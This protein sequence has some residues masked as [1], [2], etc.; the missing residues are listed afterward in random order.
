MSWGPRLKTIQPIFFFFKILKQSHIVCF[1]GLYQNVKKIG[2]E[3]EI[4]FAVLALLHFLKVGPE[5]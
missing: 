3:G 1:C 4:M 5:R 2:Q